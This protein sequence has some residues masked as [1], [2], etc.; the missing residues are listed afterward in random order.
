VTRQRGFSLVE[1]VLFIIIVGIAIGGMASLY[2]NATMHSHEPFLRQ[3]ALAVANAYMDEI[4][5]K[6]WNAAA[7]LGGVC[8]NTGASCPTGP[9]AIAIGNDGQNRNGFD[10]IDDYNGLAEVPTDAQGNPM[11]GYAGFNVNVTVA[12]P[13]AAWNGVDARDVRRIDVRVT[14]PVG[15]AVTLTSYRLNF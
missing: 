15:E 14:N 7:P 5:R 8:V 2:A 12:Q 3:R 6:R 4:L 13:G 11:P 10:D 9:V 1:L